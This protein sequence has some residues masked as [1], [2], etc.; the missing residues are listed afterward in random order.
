ME[1]KL[2]SDRQTMNAYIWL[3]AQKTLMLVA[4]LKVL[5]HTCVN[6]LLVCCDV[7]IKSRPF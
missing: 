5:R 4:C 2:V 6:I 1:K 3:D 7:E